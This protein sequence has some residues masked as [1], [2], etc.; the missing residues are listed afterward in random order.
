MAAVSSVANS[1]HAVNQTG[2]GTTAAFYYYD[3][4]GNQTLRDAPGSSNDRTIRYSADGKAHEIQM[5]NGQTTRFWYGPNGQRY[6]RQDGTTT[7]YY[8]G[9]VEVLVQNGMQTAR[10]YVAGVALQTVINGVV[11]ATRFM[12]HDHLG[13][14]IRIANVDGSIAE[15][16]DY[17]AFGDRRAYGNPSSTGGASSYTPRGFTG[18]EYVDGTQV[19]HMNGRIYDQQLGRFLQPDPVI[20]EPTNAQSWNAYTYVFNNPLAYT[21]PTGNMSL[22]QALGLVI[23]I[24]G[25]YFFPQGAK[26]WVQLA[27]TAAIGFASGYVSSG[28]LQGGAFGAFTALITFGIGN[29]ANMTGGEQLFARAFTGGVM[30]SIQGGKFGNAFVSAGMTAAIMPQVGYIQNDLGRP[31][32]GAIVGGTISKATGGKFANGAISGAIQGAMAKAPHESVRGR[33]PRNT[34]DV[35]VDPRVAALAMAEGEEAMRE[36][37]LRRYDDLDLL[38]VDV[39]DA[40][41][42]IQNK[43]HTEVGVRIFNNG[44]FFEA[45]SVTSEGQICVRGNTC[46]VSLAKSINLNGSNK[47]LVGSFHTHPWNDTFSKSDL[48]SAWA[49][50]NWSGREHTTYVTMPDRS[51]LSFD[52]G[53]VGKIPGVSDWP[54]YLN[55]TKRVR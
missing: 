34:Q 6:K 49:A 7:T 11:Q 53:L 26:L 13:S 10:R 51:V 8:V 31:A 5:G 25:M 44:G 43:W 54:G 55:H 37:R 29:A 50:R 36:I 27:Y 41:Q 1:P 17:T 30:E 48:A 45:G 38:A 22:R 33:V 12:F 19:I 52:T 15:A 18:H 42:P 16:L 2:D 24:V 23:A 32:V 9:G 39:A 47:N 35:E 46:G 28:T 4:R 14:L 40:L 3:D 20:Q 21:D